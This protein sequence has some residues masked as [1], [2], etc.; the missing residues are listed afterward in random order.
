MLLKSMLTTMTMK[1]AFD[2]S[3]KVFMVK[4]TMGGKKGLILNI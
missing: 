1:G 2:G 4:L 3:W